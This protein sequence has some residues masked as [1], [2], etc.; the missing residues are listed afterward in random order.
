M[1]GG[2]KES[3]NLKHIIGFSFLLEAHNAS[4]KFPQVYQQHYKRFLI[5]FLFAI[6]NEETV[7]LLR[8]SEA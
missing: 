1:P 8:I 3:D 5:T 4:E 7:D 6:Y 2:K